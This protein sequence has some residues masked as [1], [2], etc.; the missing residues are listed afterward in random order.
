MAV[1]SQNEL[2]AQPQKQKN[3]KKKRVERT[4]LK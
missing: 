4:K 2:R 1:M 3:S